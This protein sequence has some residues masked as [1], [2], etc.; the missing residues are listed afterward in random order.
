MNS[1]LFE[2]NSMTKR[3]KFHI[4]SSSWSNKLKCGKG[5]KRAQKKIRVLKKRELNTI[6]EE[7]SNELIEETWKILLNYALTTSLPQAPIITETPTVIT[8]TKYV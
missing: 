3:K 7:M 8:S 2:I 4:R 1:W 6:I 5:N